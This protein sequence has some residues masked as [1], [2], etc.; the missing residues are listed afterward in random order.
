MRENLIFKEVRW[1]EMYLV[2]S[3]LKEPSTFN[4]YI[5]QRDFDI[6]VYPI[7]DNVTFTFMEDFI[8]WVSE[9]D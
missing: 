1:N 4:I 7:F 3:I 9:G 2:I 8:R 6:F 5:S